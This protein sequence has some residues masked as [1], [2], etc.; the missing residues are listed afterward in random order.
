MKHLST[1]IIKLSYFFILTYL[2]AFTSCTD[3]AE[4]YKITV[5][6]NDPRMGEVSGDGYYVSGSTAVLKAIPYKGYKFVRWETDGYASGREDNPWSIY[7]HE[8]KMYRAIFQDNATVKIKDYGTT[9]N[10][11]QYHASLNMST[12]QLSFGA[13]AGS[14]YYL[15]RYKWDNSVSA[16]TFLGNSNIVFSY[17]EGGEWG[18]FASI[19]L[20]SSVLEPG[21]PYLWIYNETDNP[22]FVNG[23]QSG[24]WWSTSLLL[25]ITDIDIDNRRISFVAKGT[26]GNMAL[27]IQNN[28]DWE[29]AYYK[30]VTITGTDIPLVIEY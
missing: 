24:A 11:E 10:S 23:E 6:S 16:G 28:T 1:A 26:V 22:A 21:N 7:V 29:D 14:P 13:F 12:K 2:F 27:C 30:E 8:N 4:S 25:T 19:N 5:S 3:L 9:W 18:H 20:E 15:M 17:N